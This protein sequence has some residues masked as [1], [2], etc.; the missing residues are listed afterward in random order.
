[1]TQENRKK[2]VFTGGGT[3]GHVTPALA[4][5]EGIRNVYSDAEFHYVGLKGKAEDGMVQK[6]WASTMETGLGHLHFVST[7]SGSLKSPKVLFKLGLG[8][9]QS[10]VFLMKHQPDA[11]IAT[12]GYVSAPI[13]FASAA[14]RKFKLIRSKVFL[15]EAN[16][17]LGK[18]N[19]AAISF[20]N[21]VGFSFPG[22]KIPDAKKAFV[23]YP[24]RSSVVVN[25][26]ADK[27]TLKREARE[28]LGFPQDAKL[29]FA[30]GGSQG[31]RTINRGIV[32]ALP[33]LLADPNVY[34][35]HGTGR[36]MKGNAYN[37]LYDVKTHLELVKAQ[38]P[39]DWE[40]RYLPTDF[41]YNMGDY[42][43]ATDLVVCRGGAGSLVEVCANGV[44]SITIPKANLPGDHQAVNARVLERLNATKVI[45]ERVNVVSGQSIETIDAEEFADLVFELLN[46]EGLR[47]ELIQNAMQ[48]YD[49]NTTKNCASIV[50][51]LLGESQ[52]PELREESTPEKEIVLG[53]T[54]IQLENLLRKVRMGQMSITPEERRIALYK[55]DGWSADNG[56]VLPARAC[57]MI[58]LGRFTERL[59]VLTTFAVDP[60]KSPFTR[61][62]AF[63]GLKLCGVL[64][65]QVIDVC[66]KGC[67][68]DYFE[69]VESSLACL[70]FLL[71]NFDNYAHRIS[72]IRAKVEPLVHSK[73]FDIRMN[74]LTVL[75]EI[76]SSFE[77]LRS[78]FVANYFHPNWQVRQRLIAC[79]ASL[80]KRNLILK[81]EIQ[82]ILTKEFLQTSNGFTMQFELKEEILDLFQKEPREVVTQQLRLLIADDSIEDKQSQM[83]ELYEYAQKEKLVWQVSHLLENVAKSK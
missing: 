14:L 33:L 4:I 64:N 63:V 79:F 9:V 7:T 28:R 65:D 56:L 26:D 69:A 19:K 52:M 12:G 18:M 60:Q 81:E 54:S 20:A 16:A 45:Y 51:Y 47:N 59:D 8:F 82:T 83:E 71:P 6:A 15:H 2:I 36:Q 41:I 48:Q 17:E 62:D 58:G 74:A 30:F 42:Y 39:Q 44:A 11:I 31:A 77:E 38:L 80:L 55:I 67:N 72:E 23:G 32:E 13:L 53:T 49:P 37:G 57:R 78:S 1:M 3:G 29:L 5:A 10:L 76:A 21:K 22:T 61:R 66:L 75:T 25:R 70:S 34:I 40:D 46:D 24:V 35:V 50:Q 27:E 43:A 68:D 73:E